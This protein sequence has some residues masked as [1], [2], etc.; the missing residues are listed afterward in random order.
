MKSITGIKL[1]V[2]ALHIVVAVPVLSQNSSLRWKT[3]QVSSDTLILDSLTIYQN[4]L[5][6]FCGEKKLSSRDYFFNGIT[7]EFYFGKECADSLEL[8]SE[9]HTSELQSRPHLVCRL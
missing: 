7:R 5:Q 9:E 3:L 1:F 6:V 4:S 2:F 8:R